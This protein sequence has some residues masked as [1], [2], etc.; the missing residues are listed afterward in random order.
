MELE[1]LR[2]FLQSLIVMPFRSFILPVVLTLTVGYLLLNLLVRWVY[3]KQ[4]FPYRGSS[5]E[6]SALFARVEAPDGNEIVFIYRE[7]IDPKAPLLFYFHG[8]GLDL[9]HSYER[10]EWFRSLG[11]SVLALDY[12]GYGLSTG[13]PTGDSVRAATDSVW[14]YAIEELG[15][16]PENT[17]LWGHSLGGA[18]AAY[19]GS[20]EQFRALVL[21][22]TFRSVFSLAPTLPLL[23]RE[24]FPTEDLIEA[25]SSPIVLIH[26]SEDRIIPP[27]HSKR[28]KEKAGSNAELILIEGGRHNDLRRMAQ[29]QM[30]EVL[31]RFQDR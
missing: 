11:Y 6:D 25:V 14:N 12:P 19:L 7:N 10:I 20:K 22:S 16:R 24:P 27:S 9:G 18:P 17:V 21:Q 5:Y 1:G 8:N 2:V 3:P 23:L 13:E 4:L 28:L 30:E 31:Q 26:G 29:D 15:A